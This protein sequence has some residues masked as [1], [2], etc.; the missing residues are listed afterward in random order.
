MTLTLLAGGSSSAEEGTLTVSIHTVDDLGTPVA[1]PLKTFDRAIHPVLNNAGAGSFAILLDDP[2]IAAVQFGRVAMVTDTVSGRRIGFVIESQR[3]SVLKVEG[4]SAQVNVVSGRL[5]PALLERAVVYPEGGAN[6][7]QTQEMRVFNWANPAYDATSWSTPS[8]FITQGTNPNASSQYSPPYQPEL[9]PRNWE[10]GTAQWVLSNTYSDAPDGVWLY[11]DTFSV[12]SA[13]TYRL[14]FSVDNDAKVLLDGVVIFS[15]GASYGETYSVDVQLAAG[16]HVLAARI[17]NGPKVG[18]NPSAFIS[19][20][21]TIDDGERGS[22]VYRTTSGS[23]IKILI[24]PTVAG[25]HG[26]RYKIPAVGMTVGQALDILL[27]E[28]QERGA[29]SGWTWTFDGTNDSSG[30][31]WGEFVEVSVRAGDDY[32]TVL[33]QLAQTYIDFRVDYDALIL[34]VYAKGRMGSASGVSY[35]AGV[36]VSD[37]EVEGEG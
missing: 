1:T 25:T 36:S 28:A 8:N 6:A 19:S 24:S 35:T 7:G 37:L 14:D 30:V 5:L 12:S 18:N 21:W 20:L 22:V 15:D 32:L 23:S 11:R 16:S 29:L 33:R 31:A 34:H 4:A 10:D 13:G 27:D 26:T 9:L 3:R 17:Y 2:D